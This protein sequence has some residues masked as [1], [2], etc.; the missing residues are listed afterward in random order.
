MATSSITSFSA[1]MSL[2][3]TGREGELGTAEPG[4]NNYPAPPFPPPPEGGILLPFDLINRKLWSPERGWSLRGWQED[5]TA[6]PNPDEAS[7]PSEAGKNQGDEGNV[8]RS[9]HDRKAQEQWQGW[10]TGGAGIRTTTTTE[11]DCPEL[12]VCRAVPH[13]RLLAPLNRWVRR[14]TERR[15]G[16]PG[17]RT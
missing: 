3:H 8:E 5:A 6:F 7:R 10:A 2:K 4:E 9:C 12:P 17:G 11:P 13:T 16:D 1:P 15:P 14:G